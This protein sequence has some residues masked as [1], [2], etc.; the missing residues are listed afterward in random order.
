MIRNIQTACDKINAKHIRFHINY[1]RENQYALIPNTFKE[2]LYQY[3]TIDSFDLSITKNLTERDG[4]VGFINP[5]ATEVPNY[6]DIS[7]NKCMNNNKPCEFIDMYP[8]RKSSSDQSTGGHD[9]QHFF[10]LYMGSQSLGVKGVNSQLTPSERAYYAFDKGDERFDGTFM[11]TVYNYDGNTANW[12]KQGY[13]A[14]YNASDEDK[15][16]LAIAFR[17]FPWYTEDAEIDKYCTDHAKQFVTTGLK[18]NTKI[19]KVAENTVCR[20]YT[21][22]GVK[23]E[24]GSK[25]NTQSFS[26]AA[27]EKFISPNSLDLRLPIIILLAFLP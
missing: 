12:S 10:A 27:D 26:L 8:D 15:A 16:K 23:D 4:W 22:A 7:L 24:T 17:Y 21:S 14:Y 5:V 11:T 6:K 2:H 1:Q 3:D 13:W 18:N 20:A 9:Q 25:K 19:Y